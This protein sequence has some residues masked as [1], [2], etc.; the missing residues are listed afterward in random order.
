M[1]TI[2][3]YFYLIGGWHAS[4]ENTNRVERF[5]VKNNRWEKVS[6]M[7]E[8]RYKPG[9]CII[10]S[11]YFLKVKNISYKIK[12]LYKEFLS[13]LFDHKKINICLCMYM[14]TIC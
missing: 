13:I 2:F 5:D 14:Y 11:I 12:F 6:S 3:E 10:H 7:N 1:R 9:K 8:R 4:T